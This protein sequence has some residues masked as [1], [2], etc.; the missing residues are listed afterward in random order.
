MIKHSLKK[1][2]VLIQ[3]YKIYLNEYIG[4]GVINIVVTSHLL[5]ML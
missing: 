4:Q 1:I 2:G 5:Q 3:N